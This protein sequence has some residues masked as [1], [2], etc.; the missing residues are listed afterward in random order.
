MVVS[1]Q[2]SMLVVLAMGRWVRGVMVTVSIN[3]GNGSAGGRVV[4]CIRY[5]VP[6]CSDHAGSYVAARI[7]INDPRSRSKVQGQR[8]NV[9]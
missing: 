4:Y 6:P 9:A 8:S 2:W 5:P 1:G 3:H 7:M